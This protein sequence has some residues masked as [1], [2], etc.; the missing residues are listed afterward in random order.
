MRAR[1]SMDR[2]MEVHVRDLSLREVGDSASVVVGSFRE[3]DGTAVIAGGALAGRL[4]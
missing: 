3:F 4:A 2:K 1:R